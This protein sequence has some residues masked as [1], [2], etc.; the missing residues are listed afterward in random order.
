MGEVTVWRH[1]ANERSADRFGEVVEPDDWIKLIPRIKL[2]H[3]REW[4][5][6][7]VVGARTVSKMSFKASGRSDAPRDGCPS[8][9]N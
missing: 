2:I 3:G 1:M 9:E 4:P 7:G 8:W 6:R 5:R